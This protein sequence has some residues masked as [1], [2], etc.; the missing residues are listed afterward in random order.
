MNILVTGGASGLGRAI[1][2]KLAEGQAH[3]VFF[4]WAH[5]SEAA[6]DL[7]R[8]RRN[9]EALKCDF[10]S[11]DDVMSL[12]ARLEQLNL[13]ALVNNAFTGMRTSHFHKLP[14][15]SFT[16]SFDANVAATARISQAAIRHFR[17]VRAGRIVTILSTYVTGQP[18][19]GLAQYVAEKAYLLSLARSW[20]IEN[21]AF[22]IT[23][24]CVSPSI[25]LTP[26]TADTDTRQLEQA[27]QVHPLKRLLTPPEVADAVALLLTASL[28]INGVNLL[29]NA[30][31]RLQ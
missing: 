3:K 21:A 27:I 31:E 11:A 13:D 20:A 30:G 29:I 2:E 15:E 28:H 6:E 10:G 7:A 17:R 1:T 22:N 24:N 8:S 12:C 4:T 14:P 26:L 23:S 5:S 16:A 9:T 19:V 25:M 18:P